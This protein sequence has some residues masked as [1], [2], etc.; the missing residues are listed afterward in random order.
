MEKIAPLTDQEFA[1][2]LAEEGFAVAA[3]LFTE[4]TVAEVAPEG[5]S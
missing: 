1:A 3:D 2:L 4:V 5:Q